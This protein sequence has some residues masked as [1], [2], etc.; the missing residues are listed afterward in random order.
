MAVKIQEGFALFSRRMDAK[1]YI[2]GEDESL[3]NMES[4]KILEI[5]KERD[6]RKRKLLFDNLDLIM[7]H[8][9]EIMNMPRYAKIDAHYALRGGGAYIGP[10]AMRRRFSAAGVPVTVNITLGALLGIWDTATYKVDCSC[11]N[12]AYIRSF[13]GSPLTG[14]SVAGAICPHCKNEIHGI[15]SRPFG[16]YVRQVQNALDGEEVAVSQ[17]FASGSFGKV[18]ELCSLEKM[19][20]ELKLKEYQESH[21]E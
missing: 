19:I 16:D 8:R 4:Q 7:R 15:R 10:I 5:N 11:G 20:S 9:D 6:E 18:S 14:M 21:P 3:D 17:A 12:T 13:G 2:E 1:T